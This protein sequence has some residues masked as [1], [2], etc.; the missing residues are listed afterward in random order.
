MQTVCKT[1]ARRS[2][3]AAVPR[4]LVCL[5]LLVAA[6]GAAGRE[7]LRVL[8][9]IPPVHCFTLNVAGNLARVDS[10]LPPGG[11]AHDFQFT[12]RERRKLEAADLVILNGL[13]LEGW[14]TRA[15]QQSGP[16]RTLEAAGGLE[17]ELIGGNPHVWLDPR[18]AIRMTTNILAALQAADPPNAAGYASNATAY[19][20]RLQALDREMEAGLAGVTNRALVTAHDAFAYFARRYDLRVAGTLE[21]AA[22]VDPGA[23]H[24]SLLRRQM[25]QQRVRAIFVDAHYPARRLRQLERDFQA[26]VGVL[27]NLEGSPSKAGAYEDGMRANLRSLLKALR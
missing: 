4:V 27:D 9:S 21:P 16:K 6:A 13:G 22:D 25:E 8:T 5:F 1:K 24:L 20:A 23:A 3:L 19:V 11:S 10:L 2:G 26:V 7:K 14:L 17:S 12:F 18:L 15:I